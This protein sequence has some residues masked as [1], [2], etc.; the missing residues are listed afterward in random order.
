MGGG[1]GGGKSWLIC[2]SRLINCLRFP[3]YKSFIGR[4]ELKRLMQSTYLTWVKVCA[5]HKV[6]QD[7]WK[8]NGQYNFI[9][10]TNGS[11]VDLLDLKY[12]PTDPFF[13]RFGSLE[14][15]DGAIEEAGEIEFMSVDVL[16]SRIGRHQNK[17]LGL[18][19]TLLITGNPKKNWTHREFYKPWKEGT[20]PKNRRFIQSLYGDNPYTAEEY[21]KQLAEIRDITTKQRL[22]FGNWDYENDPTSLM[23]YD[24]ITD[25]F[26]NTVAKGEKYLVADVARYGSD[27]T[28]ITLWNGYECYAIHTY[29][30]QDTVTTALKIKEFASQETIPY[31]H[32]LIDEDGVGGGVVDNLGGVKGF[33]ANGRPFLNKVTQ[34]PD[35]FKNLKAQCA[36]KL[37]DLV[38]GHKIGVR[39]QDEQ[40]KTM[41]IEELEQV[42][43]KDADTD[44]KLQI[45]PK[46]EV[47]E[48]LG[49]SPDYGDCFV[50][51]MYFEFGDLFPDLVKSTLEQRFRINEN[52]FQSNSTK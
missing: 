43:S 32:I 4:E 21:G 51:R 22:M 6:P 10:F 39:C 36:Y 14:Y 20:L 1:A 25:L 16:R 12:L 19:P 40:V 33:V 31:S 7:Y 13:E 27:K 45:V 3:G 11:R 24:A 42:K 28:V 35:N 29:T 18:H 30:K 34:Q 44:T 23:K 37:A 50:M 2:E 47:K 15:T 9:E 52:N 5:F 8:L 49:R 26:T 48:M 41:L 17:E 46:E 38:N